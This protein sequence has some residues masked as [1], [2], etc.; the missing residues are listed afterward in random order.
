MCTVKST[1]D[2]VLLYK[3]EITL[4]GMINGLTEVGRCYGME[5]NA[6]KTKLM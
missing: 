1:D 2:L 4:Q 5:M 3:E 6:E